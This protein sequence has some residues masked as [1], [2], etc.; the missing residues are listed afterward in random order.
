MTNLITL[1][2][3]EDLTETELRSKFCNI[4]NEL[5]RRQQHA[6]DCPLTMLTLQ[7][8]QEALHRKRVRGMES[9]FTPMPK[10]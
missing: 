8:I 10:I 1:P 2:E 9:R 3:L 7:N 5:A 4:L 6:Q